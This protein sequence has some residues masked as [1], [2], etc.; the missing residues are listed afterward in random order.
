MYSPKARAIRL[1]PANFHGK[2]YH[3]MNPIFEPTWTV[4]VEL[5]EEYIYCLQRKFF[6]NTI[7]NQKHCKHNINSQIKKFMNY[8]SFN[9]FSKT[10]RLK[11]RLVEQFKDFMQHMYFKRSYFRSA[12]ICSSLPGYTATTL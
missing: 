9:P 10:V 7:Q 6:R 2:I 4:F 3:E 12:T 11:L 1:N 5:N 8:S